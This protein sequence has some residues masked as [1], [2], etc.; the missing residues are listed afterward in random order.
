MT[1]LEIKN[2]FIKYKII[3]Q[4]LINKE[5]T[6]EELK[7]LQK[8]FDWCKSSREIII[9][10]LNDIQTPPICELSY[11]NNIKRF[12]NNHYTSGCCGDHK[13]KITNL[14]KFG[15]E[16]N[17]AKNTTS[18]IKCSETML[19]KYGSTTTLGS[20]IL[21]RKVKKTIQ[22]KYGVDN[23]F[24]SEIIKEKIKT[25]NLE[26][27]G[28]EN[29]QQH[30]SIREKSIKTYLNNI[31]TIKNTRKETL[32]QNYGVENINQIGKNKWFKFS[33]QSVEV[34]KKS[35]EE[36]SIPELMQ[37]L[38]V[39]SFPVRQLYSK[40]FGKTKQL[41]L[42]SSL[43]KYLKKILPNDEIL[44][45]TRKVIPPLELDIYIP[46]KNLAIEFNGIYWHCEK[47]GKD[48]NYHLTKTN[49]CIDKDIQLIH[50]TDEEWLFNQNVI[51]LLLRSILNFSCIPE[52]RELV[53]LKISK[54]QA[55]SWINKNSI[56]PLKDETIFY[57]LFDESKQVGI[58]TLN[59]QN[60]Y[61]LNQWFL[62][63]EYNILSNYSKL[64]KTFIN[65]YN[66]EYIFS[67][68]DKKYFNGLIYKLSNFNQTE[69]IE[70]SFDVIEYEKNKF[71][72]IWNC[73]YYN[74]LWT[75]ENLNK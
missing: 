39:S 62:L 40:I 14:A 51:K 24:Q 74:F 16:H 23:L 64:L 30:K 32:L 72:K 57:G 43:V 20:K 59:E 36:K 37:E 25:T 4:K 29:P 18:R 3:T 35:F 21:S 6:I 7:E 28:V 34:I 58:L 61:Q 38:E 67:L 53:V 49:R 2:R 48:K 69:D 50:I 26:K 73:G 42:E 63:P 52:T 68:V 55:E 11:C 12:D 22:E 56:I 33:K 9:C 5:L 75:R 70:P 71:D 46:S 60:Q 17:W 47:R 27:F 45:N 10:I 8:K 44:T 19:E 31:D 66:P 65:E 13:K 54:T 1:L 41:R 15:A